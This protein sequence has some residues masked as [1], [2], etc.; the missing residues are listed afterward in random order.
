MSSGTKIAVRNKLQK[1]KVVE[2]SD[3]NN[4][5]Y[6]ISSAETSAVWQNREA[7]SKDTND[8]A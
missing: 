6:T 2:T 8:V 7:K 1:Q 5:G 3:A 4:I